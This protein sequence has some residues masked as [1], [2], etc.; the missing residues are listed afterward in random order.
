MST[1][2]RNC[3]AGANVDTAR[4]AISN[5]AR[6]RVSQGRSRASGAVSG[7]AALV[8]RIAEATAEEKMTAWSELAK[9]YTLLGEDEVC[10]TTR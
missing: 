3:H 6:S 1:C 7:A 10:F 4:A 8:T 2:G 9:L 5:D